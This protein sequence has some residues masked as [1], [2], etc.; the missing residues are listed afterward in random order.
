MET[1]PVS[2]DKMLKPFRIRD[3]L[4]DNEASAA[5]SRET[6]LDVDE[7]SCSTQKEGPCEG[8]PRDA[9]HGT[10]QVTSSEYDETVTRNPEAKLL[11]TDED[12]GESITVGKENAAF[13]SF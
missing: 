5:S 1:Q 6:Q 13:P 2:G 3:L 4:D 9:R 7:D 10:V 11:Y 12:D 8:L